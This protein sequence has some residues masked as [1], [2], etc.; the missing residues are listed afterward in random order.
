MHSQHLVA[1]VA[2][3]QN[4]DRLA[5]ARDERVARA[6]LGTRARDR[7]AATAA[8]PYLLRRA[9]VRLASLLDPGGCADG[10]TVS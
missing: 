8:S 10:A 4:A 6:A 7:R 3:A 9:R 5:R 1:A 2:A